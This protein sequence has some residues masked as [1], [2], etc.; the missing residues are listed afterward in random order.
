MTFADSV[1]P[2]VMTTIDLT[3]W[4][5]LKGFRAALQNAFEGEF[6]YRFVLSMAL[7]SG[8]VSLLPFPTVPIA[9]LTF[10]LST[11]AILYIDI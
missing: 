9:A 4:L 10:M 3:M 11:T 7:E 2:E 1:W 6:Y 8:N 5:Q